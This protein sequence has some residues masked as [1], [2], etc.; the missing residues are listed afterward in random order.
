[1]SLL[2]LLTITV[3]LLLATLCANA[4]GGA[5]WVASTGTLDTASID[6]ARFVGGAVYIRPELATGSVVIRYNVQAINGLAINNGD[7][8]R[9]FLIRFSDNGSSAQVVVKLKEY[10]IHTGVVRTK[11]TFDSNTLP[12]ATGFQLGHTDFEGIGFD[13]GSFAGFGG[14][15]D[16]KSVYFVEAT[17]SRT[18]SGGSPGLAGISLVS[19]SP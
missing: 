13:F 4:Q 7:Q 9:R 17:L 1:M 18:S 3:V 16:S 6:N 15:S 5:D 14:D 19:D 12:P 2:K 8:R 10:N 11:I